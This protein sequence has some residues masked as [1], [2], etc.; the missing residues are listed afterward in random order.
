M[1]GRRQA[2][3][4][5]AQLIGLAGREAG[6]HHGQPHRLLLKQR[7][8]QRLLQHLANLVVGIRRPAPR[9]PGAAD[10]DAPCSP[11]SARGGRSPL[12]SPGRKTRR[13]RSRGS[14]LIWARLSIWNTPIV[15]ARQI[16][17]YTA[18]SSAGMVASVSWRPVCSSTRAKHLRI[19][20][21]MPSDRQST[22]RMPS[23]SRSSLSHSMTVRPAMAAFS[24]GTSS[25]SGPCVMTMPPTCCARCRGK[26]TSSPTRLDQAAGRANESGSMP[27][28]A[29]ALGQ[30]ASSR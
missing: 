5:A 3:H 2:A 9:P 18:G 21:S 7:H 11:G 6:G 22:F 28:L 25:H 13:G 12:R 24:I 19:A 27:G 17:S 16:M 4:R 26:P 10:R 29:A 1:P 30:A 8:A 15:S 20:V 14:M 23:S